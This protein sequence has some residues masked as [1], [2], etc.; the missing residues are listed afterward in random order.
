[1]VDVGVLKETIRQNDYFMKIDLHNA[2]LSIP[3]HIDDRKFLQFTWQNEIFHFTTLAFGLLA[4]PWVFT[5]ILKPVISLLRSEDAY[6]I[7]LGR[8]ADT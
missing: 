3:V 4:A 1:M 2:Y 7:Y 5:K 8:Y 6:I